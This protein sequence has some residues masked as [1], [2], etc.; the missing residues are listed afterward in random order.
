MRRRPSAAAVAHLTNGHKRCIARPWSRAS[1]RRRFPRAHSGRDATRIIVHAAQRFRNRA[2]CSKRAARYPEVDLKAHHQ[3]AGA[4]RRSAPSPAL[5]P[6]SVV[7]ELAVQP[8]TAIAT[9]HGP[10]A[11][12]GEPFVFFPLPVIRR[13]FGDGILCR[14]FSSIA[15]LLIFWAALP[16]RLLDGTARK[17]I[18]VPRGPVLRCPEAIRVAKEN[19][20]RP[21]AV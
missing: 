1:W 15:R 7:E 5:R 8:Q 14:G 9:G 10:G 12:R 20:R 21:F 19:G 3:R 16:S 6:N 2:L 13:F 11:M 17:A 4:A 18:V